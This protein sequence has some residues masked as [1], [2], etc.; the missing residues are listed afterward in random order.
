MHDT[1]RN[2]NEWREYHYR[3]EKEYAAKI[4]ASPKGS[5]EREM[6]FE[7]GYNKVL[8]D[9]IAQYDPGGGGT[10]YTTVVL[11]IV[12]HLVDRGGRVFDFGCGGG[13]LVMALIEAGYDARGIDVSRDCIDRAKA[14]LSVISK[15]E[16]VERGEFLSF[17]ANR[18]FHCVVMDNVIEHIVPDSVGDV[19]RRCYDM[20]DEDGYLVVLT[21]HKMSGPHDVSRFFLPLGSAAEGFHLKEYSFTDLDSAL[22]GGGFKRVLGFSVHPRMFQRLGFVSKPTERAARKAK[23]T[24]N[25]LAA[26]PWNRV[27]TMNTTVA[28]GLVALL[29]PAVCVGVK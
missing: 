7:E 20:L 15:D 3:V 24:E 1:P 9:I 29:C 25:I 26:S 21:P 27:M 17:Q 4:M 12:Q 5:A 8:G 6:L 13:D 18:K 19:V 2:I 23:A 22:R 10:H 16:C 14:T 28:R 11:Q